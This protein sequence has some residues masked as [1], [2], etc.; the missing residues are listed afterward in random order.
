MKKQYDFVGSFINGFARVKLN[1]K[2]GIVDRTGEE[3]IECKY[4]NVYNF[5]NGFF[6]VRLNDEHFWINKGE[7]IKI[8]I[9]NIL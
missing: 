5:H 4:D 6:L 3:I 8:K 7:T 1:N 9:I 2:Y